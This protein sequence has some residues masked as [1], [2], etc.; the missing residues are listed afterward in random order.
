MFLLALILKVY[1]NSVTSQLSH[2]GYYNNVFVVYPQVHAIKE[3]V[4]DMQLESY[5]QCCC[6][7]DYRPTWRPGQTLR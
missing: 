4:L 2:E 7:H 6:L 3:K 1:A 5:Y